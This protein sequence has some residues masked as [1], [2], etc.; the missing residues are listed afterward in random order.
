MEPDTQLLKAWEDGV[1]L[2]DA[3]WV[4]ADLA[5]KKRFRELQQA[6]SIGDPAPHM[7]FATP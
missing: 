6:A 1:A 4:Y 5:K 7:G 3:W 2:G